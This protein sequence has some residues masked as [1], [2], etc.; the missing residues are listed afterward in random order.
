MEQRRPACRSLQ[1]R[2]S[3]P[4]SI[5]ATR[6]T[7]DPRV[8]EPCFGARQPSPDFEEQLRWEKDPAHPH[9]LGLPDSIRPTPGHRFGVPRPPCSEE[10]VVISALGLLALVLGLLLPLAHFRCPFSG[11][12]TDFGSSHPLA[13][14]RKAGMYIAC[15]TAQELLDWPSARLI[16]DGSHRQVRHCSIQCTQ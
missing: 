13:F 3:W 16:F 15:N 14:R 5:L 1:G 2:L 10:A 7:K 4:A 8:Q 12:L 11:R 9:Q 6:A